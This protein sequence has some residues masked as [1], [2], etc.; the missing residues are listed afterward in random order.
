M[1]KNMKRFIIIAILCLVAIF[2][3][4]ILPGLWYVVSV[5]M[6]GEYIGVL[7]E[8][9]YY[10]E[11]PGEGIYR[12]RSMEK[13]EKLLSVFRVESWE[14]D[15]KYLYYEKGRKLYMMDT[16]SGESSIIYEVKRQE[17]SHIG[18]YLKEDGNLIVNVYNKKL[19]TGK[20]LLLEGQSGQVLEEMPEVTEARADRELL[21]KGYGHNPAEFDGFEYY[22]SGTEIWCR[23]LQ[24][25]EE[26]QL[27]GEDTG[28]ILSAST[29]GT[30]FYAEGGALSLYRIVKDESGKPLELRLE[31]DDIMD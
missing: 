2:V 13:P 30:Y 18:F 1:R 28:H 29:D 7:T 21:L 6:G 22:F 26:Y 8:D 12:Y 25:G 15:G 23:N 11:A 17:A 9:F 14:A 27:E 16:D 31:D 24:T 10:F 19:E 5:K 3:I 4:F 20:S